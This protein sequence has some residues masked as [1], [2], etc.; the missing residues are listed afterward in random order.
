[1]IRNVGLGYVKLGQSSSTLSGGEA[2]RVKLASFLTKGTATNPIL[3]IFDEPTT[4]LHFHD[5]NKL[6]SS[7]YQLIEVGH[8]VVVIEHNMDVIKCADWVIDLGP[9]GGDEGGHLV[10]QG[11]PEGLV[12]VKE[13]H[14]AFYLREKLDEEIQN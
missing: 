5:I 12:K 6:M 2:Q 8:T 7:F 4:G 9:D 3:F 11:T 14:T 10:Y 1:M 13:S